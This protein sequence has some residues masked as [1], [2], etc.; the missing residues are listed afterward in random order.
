MQM[1]LMSTEGVDNTT[2]TCEEIHSGSCLPFS[3]TT[4]TQSF[5][6]THSPTQIIQWLH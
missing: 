5:V 4:I 1:I 6:M 2:I 3:Q